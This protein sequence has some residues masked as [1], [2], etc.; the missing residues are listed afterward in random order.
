MLSSPGVPRLHILVQSS[1][2]VLRLCIMELA[3][4]SGLTLLAL[5]SQSGLALHL[6]EQDMSNRVGKPKAVR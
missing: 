4:H 3:T 6:F 2:G 1:Q 5:F